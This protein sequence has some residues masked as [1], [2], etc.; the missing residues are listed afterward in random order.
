MGEGEKGKEEE[1]GRKGRNLLILEKE[2]E[3]W[4]TIG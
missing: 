2:R 4:V 1:K 3:S